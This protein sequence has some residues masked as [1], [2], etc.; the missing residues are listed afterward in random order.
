[1]MFLLWLKSNWRP[2][3]YATLS[4][5]VFFYV[6]YF[7]GHFIGSSDGYDKALIEQKT[8][9][10]KNAQKSRNSRESTDAKVRKMSPTDIDRTLSDNGW[11]RGS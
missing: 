9:A 6:G 11:V 5:V 10:Y 2:L 8:E 3:M 7:A 1:M 4:G